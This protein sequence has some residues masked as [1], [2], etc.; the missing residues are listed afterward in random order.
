MTPDFKL[1]RI[2]VRMNALTWWSV[3]ARMIDP[4]TRR[5]ES[6][7]QSPH[8]D[9]RRDTGCAAGSAINSGTVDGALWGGL[10]AE[11]DRGDDLI[12]VGLSR[13]RGRRS[14]RSWVRSR[15]VPSSTTEI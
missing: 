3:H 13:F 10:A 5:A 1:T 15:S 4:D 14:L 6:D 8:D 12:P 7:D 9:G 2:I 11:L